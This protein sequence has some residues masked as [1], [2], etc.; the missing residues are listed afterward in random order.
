MKLQIENWAKDNLSDSAEDIFNEAITC[1]KIGAYKSA[2]I[3]SYLAFKVTIRDRIINSEQYPDVYEESEW[4]AEVKN[5]LEDDDGW[6]KLIN[7]IIEAKNS[8]FA[9]IFDFD[10]RYNK[11]NKF[12]YWKNIRNSCAHAKKESINNSTVEQFWNYLYDNLS[13]FYVL[14]GK[15][16]LTNEL[17][18]SYKY[19]VTSEYKKKLPNILKCINSVYGNKTKECIDQFIK[20]SRIHSIGN[21]DSDVEF[22]GN[23]VNNNTQNIR[24]GFVYSL[25]DNVQCFVQCYK[26][27]PQIL[28]MSYKLDEKFIKKDINEWL[29][30]GTTNS[31]YWNLMCDLLRVCPDLLEIDKIALYNTPRWISKISFNENQKQLMDKYEI[32]NKYLEKSFSYF[33]RVEYEDIKKHNGHDEEEAVLWFQYIKWNKENVLEL[34]N[35]IYRL[36]E[37]LNNKVSESYG[38]WEEKR[39]KHFEDITKTYKQNIKDVISEESIEIC[40]KMQG[41]L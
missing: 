6:E 35:S 1:Y 12:I 19:R 40:D 36:D 18:N 31:S 13:D 2:F 4:I 16:Y 21:E 29:I 28:P 27:Y 10:E 30:E 38:S 33:F 37:R 14:G 15:K 41:W 8:K 5:K 11:V 23:F 20:L 22:W 17:C 9:D 39:L 25:M 34:S 32:F 7:N 3:M 26:M 24:E